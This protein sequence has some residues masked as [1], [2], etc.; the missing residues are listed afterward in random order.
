MAD[1]KAMSRSRNQLQT[2]YAPESFFTFEG[3]VGACI[4]HSS[5]GENAELSAATRDQIYERMLDFAHTWYDSAMHARVAQLGKPPVMP[6]QCV[7]TRL[8]DDTQSNFQM[9]GPDRLYLC[10]PSH[11][12]YTPAPLT[13]VCRTCGLFREYDNLHALRQDIQ[14]LQPDTC[15]HPRGP[16]GACHWEQLDV[17]FVHWSGGWAPATPDRWDYSP[18]RGKYRQRSQCSCGSFD[19]TLNRSSP[20][21][22]RWTFACA[23]CGTLLAPQWLQNDPSTLEMFRVPVG[24]GRLSGPTE[25]RM[26]V[27]PY[28]ASVAYYVQSDLFIDFED[29]G[30][31]QLA[32]L[33]RGNEEQLEEFI[34]RIYG[35]PRTPV[36]DA[37][38]AAALTGKPEFAAQLTE[39]LE[40]VDVIATTPDPNTLPPPMRRIAESA[41]Q[42]S[43]RNRQRLIDDLTE[44][45]VLVPRIELP[46]TIRDAIRQRDQW[47]P[48]FDPYRLAIEHATLRDTR[49]LNEAVDDGKRH[50]VPFT[51]LDSDLQPETE[52]DRVRLEQGARE[53]MTQLGID[54]MGLIRKFDLC[55]F[56]FGYSRMESQPVLAGKRDMNMPVRLNLFPPVQLEDGQRH[57]V[58][59]VQQANQAIYVR[60]NEGRVLA[61]LQALGC[62]DMFAEA[63][64]ERLGAGILR[65][66]QM[67]NRFV[68]GLPESEHPR[69]YYYLYTLLHS[70]AHLMMRQVSEFSGL[71]LGSLG[72]YIF[73]SDVAFVIYRN[74]TTMDLGNLSAMWRNSGLALMQRLVS[75]RPTQCGTGSLC[76]KRGGACPDCLL[77][78]ETSCIASNKL[79]SRSVLRSIH[80]RPKF[81]TRADRVI[82]GYLDPDL[83][84]AA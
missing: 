73:P 32:R 39:F 41:L 48:K 3:G 14:N 4:A 7:D 51:R 13:F 63:P 69:T 57:P 21:I 82:Q 27:T 15:Q 49:L 50:Y 34:A 26:E 33:R 30:Q 67:M 35:F 53:H 6:V 43:R 37:D 71:D 66:A 56:S 29:Q 65:V 77:V 68:E 81:D 19:F 78:P 55:R 70:Y 9:P 47:A 54:E 75:T 84:V 64:G 2:A 10:R 22:G 1:A 45:S 8:L 25:V 42:Q 62:E 38:V 46:A 5:A 36:T 60:L 59:V 74:G 23:R 11:M 44:R 12:E 83:A 40:A 24:S 76:T 18:G 17:V 61:W 58:Y 31:R 28:R 72:E 20:Q 16:Q 52:A 80:G 79:L